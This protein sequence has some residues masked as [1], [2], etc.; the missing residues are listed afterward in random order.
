MRCLA[1]SPSKNLTNQGVSRG[2]HCGQPAPVDKYHPHGQQII[3]TGNLA[4][5]PNSRHDWTRN[6]EDGMGWGETYNN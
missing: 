2:F 5:R 3:L 1:L 4:M 6:I